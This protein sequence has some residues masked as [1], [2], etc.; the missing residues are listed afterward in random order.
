ML[1]LASGISGSCPLSSM[2]SSNFVS[3]QTSSVSYESCSLWQHSPLSSTTPETTPLSSTLR[4]LNLII[5]YTLMIKTENEI[6][7]CFIALKC[8]IGFCTWKSGRCDGSN[9]FCIQLS[10]NRIPLSLLKTHHFT[11]MCLKWWQGQKIRQSDKNQNDCQWEYSL[12][13][14]QHHPIASGWIIQT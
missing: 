6:P 1:L 4:T 9:R 5:L 12:H 13:K 3:F 8:I 7:C 14:N 10:T 11:A 2:F